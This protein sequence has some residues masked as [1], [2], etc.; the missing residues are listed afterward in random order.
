MN[1]RLAV[2]VDVERPETLV[3]TAAFLRYSLLALGLHK[4]AWRCRVGA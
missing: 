3:D 1:R 2:L 4:E